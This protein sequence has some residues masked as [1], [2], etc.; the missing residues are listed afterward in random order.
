MRVLITG[1]DGYIG[2][3]LVPLF[4]AAGHDVAGIDSGLFSDYTVGAEPDPV[5]TARTD[6]R[7][8]TPAH[9]EG[10]DAVVHLA[11]ISNDPLGDLNPATTYDVNARGTVVAARRPR[12]PACRA[13]SSPPPAASTARTATSPSTRPPTST[14]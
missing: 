14:R 6:V 2:T 1:H 13:S 8:T 7:D 9:F 5:P 3:R 12:P 4:R 11:A 10:F